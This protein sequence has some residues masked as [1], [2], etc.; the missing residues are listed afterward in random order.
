MGVGVLI[1]KKKV[2]NRLVN[3][4]KRRDQLHCSYI[5]F[6]VSV[7]HLVKYLRKN[8]A[9]RFFKT[10]ALALNSVFLENQLR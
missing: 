9:V 6:F 2:T 8:L 1:V 7:I 4:P 5:K 10:F 3:K